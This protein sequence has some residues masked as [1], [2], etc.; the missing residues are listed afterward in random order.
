MIKVGNG[1][2]RQLFSDWYKIIFFICRYFSYWLRLCD[3]PGCKAKSEIGRWGWNSKFQ[4]SDLSSSC[5][6]SQPQL[7]T[8]IH[9]CMARINTRNTS[10]VM[11]GPF[12][13]YALYLEQQQFQ[14]QLSICLQPL[15]W[16]IRFWHK[17]VKICLIYDF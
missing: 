1:E 5:S 15:N 10:L 8:N 13:C 4:S 12:S 14:S 11:C 17:L 2:G 7:L 9:I 3:Y 16:F 6:I